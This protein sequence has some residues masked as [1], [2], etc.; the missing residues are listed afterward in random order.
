MWW[1][2]RNRSKEQKRHENKQNK[3]KCLSSS[4]FA[5]LRKGQ[6]RY[7]WR[8]AE[9]RCFASWK[10]FQ[11]PL[12]L[13]VKVILQ[14][15]GG[16]RPNVL[17]SIRILP[18]DSPR[19]FSCVLTARALLPLAMFCCYR[20]KGWYAL[21][22]QIAHE[23]W[24]RVQTV[25]AFWLWPSVVSLFISVTSDMSPTGDL[26]VASIFAG[27]HALLSLLRGF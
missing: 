26:L 4:L 18:P 13:I 15:V 7:P 20:K 5:S 25:S 17:P 10:L 16:F 14:F 8:L 19:C 21:V 22:V 3:N 2:L 9:V 12:S 1:S 23:H 6:E 27:E 24:S 11:F